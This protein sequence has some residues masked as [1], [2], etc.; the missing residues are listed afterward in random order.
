MFRKT[1]WKV[2]GALAGLF[3]LLNSVKPLQ[4]D[5]AAYYYYAAQIAEH[6]SDPYGFFIHWYQKPERAD[7]ILAPPVLPYWWAIAIRLFGERPFL[8]KLW[9]L[10]FSLLFVGALYVLFRR[11]ARGL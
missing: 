7:H 6:P 2:L 9:L 1:P 10:P 8:W 5:D 11:F 4:V 3:T